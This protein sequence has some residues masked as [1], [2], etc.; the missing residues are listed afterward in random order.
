MAT[1]KLS[2]ISILGASGAV[3]Q[4]LVQLLQ[5]NACECK[6]ELFTSHR[7]A[8]TNCPNSGLIYQS[9]NAF[10]ESS[11]DVAFLALDD[12][13]VKKL[14]RC[15]KM[16]SRFI[17]DKSAAFRLSDNIP[18]IIPEVNA[19]AFTLEDQWIASPNCTTT[20]ATMALAP[21]HTAFGLHTV[22][23]ASYQSASGAG[24]KGV[25]E[26]K[27]QIHS[28]SNGIPLNR[29][30]QSATIFPETLAFNAIPQIGSIDECGVSSEESKLLY[31]TRKILGIDDLRIYSTCVR[32][33]TLRSHGIAITAF[34]KKEFTVN[35]AITVWKQFPGLIV[36]AE[37]YTT[38]I[39]SSNQTNCF[40]GRI[41]K[42]L[43]D[44]Q[45]ISFF[46]T[47]DQILK[48]ASYNAY[49]IFQ[50]IERR[51]TGR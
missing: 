11:C 35:D 24:V 44:S 41:R 29:L 42:E 51:L 32:V 50:E 15:L 27:N 39:Y 49:Q 12:D 22:I 21:L 14:E 23:A 7:S 19:N 6:L 3:G 38:P 20:I 5:K 8:G 45:S 37:R 30:E 13:T 33:P 18:L 17:I 43:G 16:N 34:L 4:E 48:G 31:E 46:V 25:E 9:L 40:I 36:N 47:G 1:K 2:R 26:L 28:W 10:L